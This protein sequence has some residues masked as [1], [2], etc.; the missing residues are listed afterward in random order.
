MRTASLIAF[1]I[2]LT[3]SASFAR[4][5]SVQFSNGRVIGTDWFLRRASRHRSDIFTIA[6][7][8]ERRYYLS[9]LTENIC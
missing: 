6:R 5:A 1:A 4:A 7:L 3:E 9:T 2:L 8:R